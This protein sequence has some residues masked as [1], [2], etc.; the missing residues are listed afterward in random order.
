MIKFSGVI[1]TY[2]EEEKIGTCI[3]SLIGVADEIIVVDSISTD[4]TKSICKELNVTFIE[5]KFLGYIE[6]KNFALKQASF[7]YIISL[8][9]DEALSP[10]LSENILKLKSNWKYD[11]YFCKRS[12]YFCGQ[13]IKHTCWSPDKKLRIFD[14][15]KAQWEGI[16][17]HDQI[18]LHNKKAKTGFIKGQILHDTH[19]DY[20]DYNEKVERFST[21]AAKSYFELGR[22]APLRKILINPTWAFFHSYIIKLGFLDG[23]NGLIISIQTANTRF[24]KYIKLRELIKNNK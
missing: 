15:R 20:S 16:N 11:G 1:I 17:P 21:I 6:Q 14:R 2:N 3:K 12:N 24:L 5:Q 13:W 4:N 7:N 9:A 18:K 23:M 19:K 10:E 22:K 8:D